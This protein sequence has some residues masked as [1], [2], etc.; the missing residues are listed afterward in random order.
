MD[1]L[2]PTPFSPLGLPLAAAVRDPRA[3]AY[4][5]P[6][7]AYSPDEAFPE[8]PFGR[9]TLSRR[10]N[11][12]YRL[13]RRAL[14]LLGLDR[15]R[16]GTPEWNPLGA[17]VRKGQRVLVKPNLVLETNLLGPGE[18]PHAVVTHASIAR[19]VLDYV[20]IALGEDAG[21]IRIGDAP[22][23]QCRFAEAAA[24]SGF[25][26]VAEFYRRETG[27]DLGP[28]DFRLLVTDRDRR[29]QVVRCTEKR[30]EAGRFVEVDLGGLSELVPVEER[31]DTFRVTCYDPREMARHHA[32]GRHRYLVSRAVL[33]ADVVV[34]LPKLKTHR[35]SGVTGALKNLVGINGHKDRLPHHRAGAPADGSDAYA[36]RSALKRWGEAALDRFNVAKSVPAQTALQLASRA[37]IRAG[38]RQKG[39]FTFEGSWHG[40]DTIWR[41]VL[42]LNRVLLYAD[43]TGALGDAPR[44]IHVSIADAIVAGEGEGPLEPTPKRIGVVTAGTNAAVLDR[45]HA[46][47]MGF[48]PERIP[49]VANAFARRSG[50]RPLVACAPEDVR[51]STEEGLFEPEALGRAWDLAFVPPAG[52]RGHVERA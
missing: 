45:V 29:L 6:G 46:A 32:P 31:S 51:V 2:R 27:A 12:V 25:T 38:M 41:T 10:E 37:L 14:F 50:P 17:F 35:K 24:R 7:D 43:E 34:S 21:T 26:E 33:E 28:E 44:R 5:E 1:R 52:W 11:R 3:V 4:P 36:R 8:Y 30:D 40:N 23:Q 39:D 16:F 42:D 20:F 15:E 9:E 48:C 22:I 49:V 18:D 47:L 13:V 19:A